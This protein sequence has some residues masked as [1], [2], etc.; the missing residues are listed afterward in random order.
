MKNK[1]LYIFAPSVSR[2]DGGIPS[3]AYYMATYFKQNCKVKCY[4][5][6]ESNEKIE[7]VDVYYPNTTNLL[8]KTLRNKKRFLKDC[9]QDEEGK[10]IICMSWRYALVAYFTAAKMG[11]PYV[12]MTHGNDI[13]S[14]SKKRK[15]LKEKAEE[16]LRKKILE[17][18]DCICSISEYT[19]E[20]VS[21]IVPG[22]EIILIHPCSGEPVKTIEEIGAA[23]TKGTDVKS[24]R[25][26][27][28]VGRLEARKGNI[29]VVEAMA[30]LH[31]KY[32]DLK[33]YI[34]GKGPYENAIRSRI[35]EL[36][37]EDTC[38][39][40][41]RVSEEKKKELLDGCSIFAMPSFIIENE[42][43]VEGFGIVYIEANAHGKPVIASKSGGVPDAVI[44][45]KTGVLAGEK[46][47]CEI[48][49]AIDDIISGNLI[50][51]AEDCLKWA[52]KHYYMNI[53]RE[54]DNLFESI[55]EK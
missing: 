7:G 10:L 9:R 27:L 49:K 19:R 22:R 33:Y 44:D 36:N 54:Y 5:V 35:K 26:I 12:V 25:Y 39:M 24:G 3:V 53:M 50:I 11:I 17:K 41:G 20:K 8:L 2:T 55:I 52:N 30:S 48:A 13:L 51:S 16:K 37:L 14:S 1:S 23:Q 47:V 46:N 34:A 38:I 28:S 43:S 31:A 45:G 29:L 15:S 42:K 40:L 32:P 6:L 4:S 21:R 18:A